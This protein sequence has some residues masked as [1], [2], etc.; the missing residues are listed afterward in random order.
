MAT[1]NL[2]NHGV[3]PRFLEADLTHIDPAYFADIHEYAKDY[4]AH[5]KAGRGMLISG[6]VG[7]GKSYAIVALMKLLREQQDS[8]FDFYFITAPDLFDLMDDKRAVDSYRSK[9]WVDVFNTVPALVINDLGKE[10]RSKGQGESVTIKLGRLLR[11]RHEA[12]LPVFVTTNLPLVEPKKKGTIKSAT[13]QGVYG[14]S[15]WSLLYEMTAFRAQVNAPDRRIPMK[16]DVDDA[17]A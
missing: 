4:A 11:R 1:I 8:R 7:S 5:L 12:M 16:E 6:S 9:A 17:E 14:Q 2:K 15:I 13:L 10:D 3:G